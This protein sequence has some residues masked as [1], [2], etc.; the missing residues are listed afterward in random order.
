MRE[1]FL[2]DLKVKESFKERCLLAATVTGLLALLSAWFAHRNVCSSG[3]YEALTGRHTF[4]KE[5][6]LHSRLILVTDHWELSAP[7]FSFA[8]R[9]R[10]WGLESPG[11]LVI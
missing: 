4:R 11:Q 9:G 3:T 8:Q 6:V 1:G 5:A 2:Q 10:N 7:V